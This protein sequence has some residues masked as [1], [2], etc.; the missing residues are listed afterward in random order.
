MMSTTEIEFVKHGGNEVSVLVQS[1]EGERTLKEKLSSIELE[2]ARSIRELEINKLK[3]LRSHHNLLPKTVIISRNSAKVEIKKK[4]EYAKQ[5]QRQCQQSLK[6]RKD[7]F[8]DALKKRPLS[9]TSSVRDKQVA[10]LEALRREEEEKVNN[11][12]RLPD[13]ALHSQD[14]A[15]FQQS[16]QATNQNQR[17]REQ[18]FIN[19]VNVILETLKGNRNQ[20]D[21]GRSESR[22]G[23]FD[24]LT[25]HI[26]STYAGISVEAEETEMAIDAE[27]S[28][29]VSECHIQNGKTSEETKD[30]RVARETLPVDTTSAT[31]IQE[32]KHFPAD[33]EDVSSSD[34]LSDTKYSGP[35]NKALQMW[36]AVR[37]EEKN[38]HKRRAQEEKKR[39]KS[40]EVKTEGITT[41][42]NRAD[43]SIHVI[44]PVKTSRDLPFIN[45][46]Q[47]NNNSLPPIT[48][49]SPERRNYS[50]ARGIHRCDGSLSPKKTTSPKSSSLLSVDNLPQEDVSQLR[51]RVH[52]WS[53]GQQGKP[54]SLSLV[55]RRR[56][57][58]GS[59]PES[60]PFRQT[61]PVPLE[62]PNCS[63]TV[64]IV[65]ED[66]GPLLPRR[67]SIFSVQI[68]KIHKN[69]NNSSPTE[70]DENT[71]TSS[72]TENKTSE[73]EGESTKESHDNRVSLNTD[74]VENDVKLNPDEL[75]LRLETN[76]CSA[77]S[78]STIAS[79]VNDKTRSGAPG[80]REVGGGGRRMSVQTQGALRMWAS[81][82]R[83]EADA[84][85]GL[86]GAS[87]RIAL[88]KVVEA[89]AGVDEQ[90]QRLEHVRRNSL[91]RVPLNL[92]RR[93]SLEAA[94][95]KAI[96]KTRMRRG[97]IS[98]PYKGTADVR[99]E[100]YKFLQR[101]F[102]TSELRRM[103]LSSVEGQLHSGTSVE[104][105]TGRRNSL[106][107]SGQSQPLSSRRGSNAA[108]HHFSSGKKTKFNEQSTVNQVKKL[109]SAMESVRGSSLRRPNTTETSPSNMSR[110]SPSVAS[111]SSLPLD[112]YSKSETTSQKPGRSY[113]WAPDVTNTQDWHILALELLARNRQ[114]VAKFHTVRGLLQGLAEEYR[115]QTTSMMYDE[116]R[117]CTYLRLP[118]RLLPPDLKDCDASSIFEHPL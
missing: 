86:D 44:P 12:G 14:L 57:S 19:S 85:D 72:A 34:D 45:G 78:E 75:G 1:R 21:Q 30:A 3:F 93:T 60:R 118:N 46:R 38:A 109:T 110:A 100:V 95:D 33:E 24:Y 56:S 26:L 91:S 11:G 48:H 31:S 6:Q 94:D 103:S 117:Y 105:I 92:Y 22:Q 102:S 68:D 90:V 66:N 88:D 7:A 65:H 111:K 53:S 29:E 115:K 42:V 84:D 23:K 112:A 28:T 58:V 35:P 61:L 79:L 41:Q 99:D 49:S 40:T 27:N 13:Y 17:K 73:G 62:R 107:Q 36:A 39:A 104:D 55:S 83:Q 108:Q 113:S 10:R 8:M 51:A 52:S 63:N 116:L 2:K 15:S 5:D 87:Y 18:P 64:V 59:R 106:S 96:E 43:V 74:C 82:Q 37:R 16:F 80:G 70:D 50:N 76:S 98:E 54:E 101:K 89:A 97:S 4:I 32:S 69:S 67:K 9:N 81:V 114:G 71:H 25:R 77:R 47:S 20:Q